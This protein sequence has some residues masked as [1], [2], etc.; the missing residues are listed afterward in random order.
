MTANKQQ[1]V[2]A[3]FCKKISDE[4]ISPSGPAFL[5]NPCHAWILPEDDYQ[6]EPQAAALT[7]DQQRMVPSKQQRVG[8]TPEMIAI[9]DLRRMS[10]AP[11]IMKAPNPTIKRALKLT[12][13]VHCR[14]TRNNV[15][16]TVPPIT[17]VPQ[18]HPPPTA[19]EATPVRQSPR[20][21][22][23]APRNHD[24]NLPQK[25]AKVRFTP[26]AGCLRNHNI[27]SQQVLNFLSDEVWNNSAPSYT[28]KN[29]RP[30][31]NA[32]AANLEHLV[33][34]MIHPTTGETI[35]SYKKLMNNPATTEI[36]QTPF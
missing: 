2:L 12:K 11:P 15:P 16:G 3:M 9:E 22:K 27:I 32:T 4:M 18:R 28:P 29:L 7:W 30:K 24:A 33:M 36:W 6:R 1:R 14:L 34:P 26:I 23:T 25:I 31:D 20:L 19:T 5:T 8:P 21:D 10:N 13:R 35:T 17:R